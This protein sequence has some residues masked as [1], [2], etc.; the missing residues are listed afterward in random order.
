MDYSS[1]KN[2]MKPTRTRKLKSRASRSGS[3]DILLDSNLLASKLFSYLICHGEDCRLAIDRVA[4]R[5]RKFSDGKSYDSKEAL[6]FVDKFRDKFIVKNVEGTK[7]V[8]ARTAVKIC[9]AFQEGKCKAG[10]CRGLHICRFFLAG[11]NSKYLHVYYLN[12]IVFQEV[13]FILKYIM[14]SSQIYVMSVIYL[15]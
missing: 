11:M 10:G 6:A 15:S 4:K 5:L 2:N 3:P 14:L 12:K 7:F 1:L 13:M 9:D 8:E